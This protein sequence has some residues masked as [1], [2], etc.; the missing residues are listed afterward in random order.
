MAQP[1]RLVALGVI[2]R[3]H[4]VA[5]ELRVHRFNASSTLLLERR[6]VWLRRGDDV[7]EHRVEGSRLHAG[8][9]LLRLRGVEGRDAADALR[10]V[11][12]CVPRDALPP[13]DPDEVYLADLIGLQARLADGSVAGEIVDVVSY[14]SADC[15]LLRSDEGD[16]EVPLL[17]PYASN[18]DLTARTITVAH[19]EDLEILRSRK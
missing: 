10:G 7:R 6:S 12:V 3:P 11:E 9:V 14:P 19:L 16:R 8:F 2:A 4:G 1:E 13:P 5:G 15:L 17:P 18:V